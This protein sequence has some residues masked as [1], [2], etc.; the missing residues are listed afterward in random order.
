VNLSR[1]REGPYLNADKHPLPSIDQLKLSCAVQGAL[2]PDNLLRNVEMSS[3]ISAN[4]AGVADRIAERSIERKKVMAQKAAVHKKE[5]SLVNKTVHAAGGEAQVF[6][7]I[8]GG[9][10]VSKLCA[11]LELAQGTFYDWVERVPGRRET[12][13][14]ARSLA[15]H[16]L[17]D[18]TLEIVDSA[19]IEEVQLAKLRA[20]IR[21]KLAA[22]HNRAY[23]GNAESPLVNI[24]LGSLRL[25]ALRERAI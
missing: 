16:A 7:L 14:R 12:L 6:H 19:T 2:R 4:I 1:V 11:T 23:Y 10:T 8:A 20:D 21:L 18:Q 3:A 15:A 5:V 9:M 25:D 13:N 17:A 22:K 24:N